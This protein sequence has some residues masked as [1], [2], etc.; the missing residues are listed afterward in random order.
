M[1]A[2]ELKRKKT[3]M[4]RIEDA[5]DSRF[6]RRFMAVAYGLGASVV[7]IGALFKITHIKGANEALFVGMVTEAIIF[8]LSALQ[9]P[10][11][12]PDWSK[13]HPEFMEDY[14]G[15]TIDEPL[16]SSGRT[17]GQS[18]M[19]DEMLQEAKIDQ[20]LINR[21]GTGLKK[22]GDSADKLNEV[23]HASVASKEFVNSMQTA[24]KSAASLG[25]SYE[26][27]AKAL[28]EELNVSSDFSSRIKEAS[29]AASGLKETYSQ[30]SKSLK[31]DIDASRKL[32]ESIRQASESAGKL[33][34]SYFKSS[35]SIA[36]NI[37][38]LQKSTGK[39]TA[40]NEQLGKLSENLAS[41]NTLYELQM[42]N[43]S[44]QANISEQLQKTMQKFLGD[45]EASAGK[46][47]EYQKQMD[48]LTQ[49]MSSLNSI[50]GNMLSAM[51]VK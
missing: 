21:L 14:H 27:T 35:E 19:L 33:S 3:P 36:K 17:G 32:S 24:T 50:Y 37:E 46:T 8:A 15:I 2:A 11:V 4:S 44:Q 18:S 9:K 31:D 10:H 48:A 7:I 49:R 40:F 29:Q 26:A 42:K 25:Q 47:L 38:Q 39:N 6:F 22:L 28:Q 1:K 20:E 51:N 30:A 41:L 13:V 34:D 43:S 16:P 45:V 23:S 5:L 12:E